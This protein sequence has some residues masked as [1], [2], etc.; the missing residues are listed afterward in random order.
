MNFFDNLYGNDKDRE[1]KSSVLILIKMMLADG[2]ID[3]R[4]KALLIAICQ[5]R[6]IPPNVLDEA[7]EHP[8]N[9]SF[10]PPKSAEERGSLLF[11]LVWMM[12]ADTN[13][14]AK[15]M[16]VA[17]KVAKSL[18][19]DP[20]TVPDLVAKIVSSV[21]QAMQDNQSRLAAKQKVAA[22]IDNFLGA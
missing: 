7:M 10:Q 5:K 6:D 18:G 13:V 15:E 19:F 21:K 11:D 12:L 3:P 22:E 2:V 16:E 17:I 9:I 4:E 14:D 8:E 1:Q 20:E